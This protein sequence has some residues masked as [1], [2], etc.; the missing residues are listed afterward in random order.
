M[1]NLPYQEHLNRKLQD[2]EF[3]AHY[4]A[5]YLEDGTPEEIATAISKILY[6]RK[7][8]E[9]PKI[10]GSLIEHNRDVIRQSGVRV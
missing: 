9:L 7:E 10:Y 2:S 1:N 5:T 3:A 8:A 6:A 4:L